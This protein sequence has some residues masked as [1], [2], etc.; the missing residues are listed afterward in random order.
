VKKSGPWLLPC[1]AL[2]ACAPEIGDECSANVDCSPNG[3]RVCDVTSPGGYCMILGCRSG[4]CP[5]E[6]VCVSYGDG[7]GRQTFCMRHCGS[8]DDCRGEYQCFNPGRYAASRAEDPT[9]DPNDYGRIIDED[10]A[11]SGFCTRVFD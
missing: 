10:P 7:V 11:G 9:F 4:G 2:A 5:E 3:D 1:F 6:A 8:G